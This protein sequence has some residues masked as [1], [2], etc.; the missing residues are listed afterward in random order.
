MLDAIDE[1]EDGEGDL[2]LDGDSDENDGEDGQ[3]PGDAKAGNKN[4][5][6][7]AQNKGKLKKDNGKKNAED[8]LAAKEKK[9]AVPRAPWRMKKEEKAK[10][11]ADKAKAESSAKPKK[12]NKIL[13]SMPANW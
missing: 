8:D 2:D 6:N 3:E 1:D 7:A 12:N 13:A 5:Q 10:E 11:A 4:S 9:P